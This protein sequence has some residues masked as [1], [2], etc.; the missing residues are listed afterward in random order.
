MLAEEKIEVLLKELIKDSDPRTSK[1]IISLNKSL[2]RYVKAGGRDF[3][4]A[5]IARLTMQDNGPKEQS[6]RNKNKGGESFRKL[7]NGWASIY[8]SSQSSNSS[9]IK[10]NDD[11]IVNKI[12]DPAV[13]GYF[14]IVLAE[15]KKLL[16][17]NKLLKE[18]L[19]V[20]YDNRNTIVVDDNIDKVETITDYILDDIEIEALN[21]SISSELMVKMGWSHD[22]LGRVKMG[23]VRIY[24]PGYISAIKKILKS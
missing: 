18:N 17:E 14:N 20:V 8:P 10:I 24:K 9:S 11:E 23:N 21:H 12:N 5:T 13:R 16:R 4:V 1:K 19:N 22:E 3:R 6:I 2:R 15:R 7:I